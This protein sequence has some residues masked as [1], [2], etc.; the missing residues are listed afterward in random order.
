MLAV[1]EE[2]VLPSHQDL[3]CQIQQ[4]RYEPQQVTGVAQSG[5]GVGPAQLGGRV[6]AREEEKEEDQT[7]VETEVLARPLF[8][9]AQ[10]DLP[11]APLSVETVKERA[12][13]L[14]RE[15]DDFLP[16]PPWTRGE[17]AQC[18]PPPISE[19]E[20]QLD[21]TL[22]DSHQQQGASGSVLEAARS[23]RSLQPWEGETQLPLSSWEGMK[24]HLN[25]ENGAAMA[26]GKHAL[27]LLPSALLSPCTGFCLN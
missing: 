18:H 12:A 24:M 14:E 23:A 27:H 2:E 26:R 7:V 4:P 6:A 13:V 21:L 22:P 25:V 10:I 20:E 17:G 3:S 5:P 15:L 9:L 16:P 1:P 19:G 8:E 11:V